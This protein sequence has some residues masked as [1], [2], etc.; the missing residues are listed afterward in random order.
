MFALSWNIKKLE[1]LFTQHAQAN[2]KLASWLTAQ[3]SPALCTAWCWL[4]LHNLCTGHQKQ[5]SWQLRKKWQ[6]DQLTCHLMKKTSPPN[7]SNP[8]RHL[9]GRRPPAN[10]TVIR[11]LPLFWTPLLPFSPA[12]PKTNSTL[13]PKSWCPARSNSLQQSTKYGMRTT[14]A[15]LK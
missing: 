12:Q 15:Y 7:H 4:G 13:M 6:K 3:H 8:Q 5:V 9:L 11:F 1:L 2:C 10:I 14:P